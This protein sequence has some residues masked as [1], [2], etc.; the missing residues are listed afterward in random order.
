[1][2]LCGCSYI[3][4]PEIIF[5]Q[6]IFRVYEV[7]FKNVSLGV[8]ESIF[9]GTSSHTRMTL[10]ARNTCPWDLVPFSKK[11]L[12]FLA[13][14]LTTVDLSF[15]FYISF[16]SVLITIT[17][18]EEQVVIFMT[19]SQLKNRV[20]KSSCFS[21]AKPFFPPFTPKSMESLSLGES[22]YFLF[23]GFSTPGVR[24]GTLQLLRHFIININI[25]HYYK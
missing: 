21:F 11:A 8:T 3:S 4:R 6:M 25:I 7:I 18:F 5:D 24:L 13:L 10:G 12:P 14:S 1:M 2:G 19:V 17:S 9:M 15:V 23:R 16:T 20:D 22:V